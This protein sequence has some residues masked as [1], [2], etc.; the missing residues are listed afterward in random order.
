MD[1]H[2]MTKRATGIQKSDRTMATNV[3]AT[4]NGRKQHPAEYIKWMVWA[5]ENLVK[6]Q[7][8]K[9]FELQQQIGPLHIPQKWDQEG[10]TLVADRPGGGSDSGILRQNQSDKMSSTVAVAATHIKDGLTGEKHA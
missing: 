5:S 8:Q 9:T 2:N 4:P 7:Q 6:I 3:G 1:A 10:E